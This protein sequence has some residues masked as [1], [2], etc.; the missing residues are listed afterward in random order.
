MLR[1]AIELHRQGRLEEA[2]TAY[3]AALQGN[4]NDGEAL[5]GLGA[6]RRMRGDLAE[7]AALISRAHVLAPEQPKLLMMLRAVQFEL[8]NADA[9]GVA[10]ERVHA[11]C[12]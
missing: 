3:R 6:V 10:Y 11:L 8:S 2:E 7:S 9:S 12:P 1:E 4:P 5:R